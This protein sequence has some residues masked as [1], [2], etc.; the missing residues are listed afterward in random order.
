MTSSQS[1]RGAVVIQVAMD[2]EAAPFLAAAESREHLRTLGPADFHRLEFDFGPAVLIRSG[3]GLANAATATTQAAMLYEPR[4]VISAGSAGGV[5]EDIAIADVVIADGVRFH[6]SDATAFGYE[7]GQVPD[8]PAAYA[9]DAQLLATGR[10]WAEDKT[11]VK[12]GEALSGASFITEANIGHMRH[13]F[14]AGLSTDMETAAIAQTAHIFGIPFGAVRAISDLC[15]P[16]AEDD[17]SLSVDE[18]AEMS[19]QATLGLLRALYA[20]SGADIADV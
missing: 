19:A 11:R 15:G 16:K 10:H 9:A 7:P 6:D 12:F 2:Q 5:G 18:A 3:I 1:P 8:M 13:T 14:P 4:A 20:Q 17:F